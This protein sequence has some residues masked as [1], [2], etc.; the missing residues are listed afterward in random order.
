MHN[1][2]NNCER[3]SYSNNLMWYYEFHIDLP[4]AVYKLHAFVQDGV[5][6][7]SASPALQMLDYD[8]NLHIDLASVVDGFLKQVMSLKMMDFW[9]QSHTA[10]F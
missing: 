9:L 10:S 2:Y 7:A 5:C 3:N 1:N 4:S 8:I 6:V